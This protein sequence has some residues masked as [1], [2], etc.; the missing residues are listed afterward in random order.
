MSSAF[1]PVALSVVAH[2]LGAV[3]AERDPPQQRVAHLDLGLLQAVDEFLGA[4]RQLAAGVADLA[5]VVRVDL[6]PVLGLL[7]QRLGLAGASVVWPTIGTS[8]PMRRA[9]CRCATGS[10]R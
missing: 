9:Y 4:R 2:H 10:R 7:E 8:Q 6:V 1:G 3:P 5:E